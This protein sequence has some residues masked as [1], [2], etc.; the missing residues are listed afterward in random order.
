MMTI[1]DV[2]RAAGVSVATVSRVQNGSAL[3]KEATRQR[4]GEV[5]RRLGYAPH[6]A[7][8]TLITSRTSTIGVL[9]PDLY[10]EFFSEVIRGIDQTAQRHGFHLLVSSSHDEAEAV[11][12]ALRS[13]R[14]RVDGLIVMWPELD[15]SMLP[16]FPAGFPVVLLSAP[17]VTS[18]FDVIRIANFEG[19]YDMVSHLLQ[20]G[21][22]RIGI[23]KGAEG[24]ADASERLRGYR[25]ALVD[26]GIEPGPFEAAGAFTE[27][28][29]FHAARDLLHREV[30]PTAIFAAND[31]MAIGALSALRDAS[32]HVPDDVALAG[33]DDIP[34]ARYMDPPLSTVRVNISA[35]GELATTRLLAAVRDRENH[36]PRMETLPTTVVLR[37][38]SQPP[39]PVS[40]P[41][42]QSARPATVTVTSLMRHI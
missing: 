15:E 39:P 12:T 33:F 18:G 36:T 34:M 8:R 2:A 14:G 23:L 5:V 7:A 21:H 31:A 30:A 19:A 6:A 1:R 37:G 26:A 4:V 41:A 27:E 28:S 38:S 22:R 17:L 13:M 11:R 42:S 10:G 35:L 24:N 29:G 20:L 40:H 3:V 16:N 32:L 9:L 25:A